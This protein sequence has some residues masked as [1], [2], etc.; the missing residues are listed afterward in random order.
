M[1]FLPVVEYFAYV[2]FL[3]LRRQSKERPQ[4]SA[5][6]SAFHESAE[7]EIRLD[8]RNEYEDPDDPF[9]NVVRDFLAFLGAHPTIDVVDLFGIGRIVEFEFAGHSG[10]WKTDTGEWYPFHVRSQREVSASG[11]AFSG[12]HAIED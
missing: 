5:V 1:V 11:L 10:V 6:Q 8:E 4:S 12:A 7:H 9:P 3:L 2:A